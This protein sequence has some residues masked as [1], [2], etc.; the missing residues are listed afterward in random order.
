MIF[1]SMKPHLQ[2]WKVYFDMVQVMDW[3]VTHREDHAASNKLETE[4]AT[5]L[6]ASPRVFRICE[7][8]ERNRILM[9]HF[10]KDLPVQFEFEDSG[11]VNVGLRDALSKGRYAFRDAVTRVSE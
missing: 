9:I 4:L 11:S 6:V 7:P 3:M 2:F 1:P 10:S 8:L 5:D